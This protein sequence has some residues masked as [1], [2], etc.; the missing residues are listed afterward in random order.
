[1]TVA[2][3]FNVIFGKAMDEKEHLKSLSKNEKRFLSNFVCA[4]CGHRLDRVGCSAIYGPCDNQTRINRRTKA[5]NGYR[6]R[7][8]NLSLKNDRKP[9]S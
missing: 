2:A 1:M 8:N 3:E 6:P 9:A 7:K 5:L 4:W